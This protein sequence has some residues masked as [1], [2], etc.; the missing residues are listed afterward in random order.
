MGLVLMA[1][2]FAGGAVGF[3]FSAIA[4]F[5]SMVLTIRNAKARRQVWWT[6]AVVFVV[7]LAACIVAVVQYPYDT[8]RPGSDYDVA[9]RNLFLQGLGYFASPGIAAIVAAVA[10][11]IAPRKSGPHR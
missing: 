6:F 5:G 4:G 7:V 1:G 9:M 2:M 3:I 10:T 8:V 11:F